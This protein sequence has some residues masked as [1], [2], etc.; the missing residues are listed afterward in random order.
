ML[1]NEK[2]S[3]VRARMNLKGFRIQL[4]VALHLIPL[5]KKV[6]FSVLSNNLTRVG[7]AHR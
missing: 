7:S 1:S 3:R 4:C 2:K 6:N 5:M